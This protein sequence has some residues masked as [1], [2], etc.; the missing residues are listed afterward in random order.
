MMGLWGIYFA[1]K[2]DFLIWKKDGL[3]KEHKSVERELKDQN[4][5]DDRQKLRSFFSGCFMYRLKYEEST[6]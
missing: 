5:A 2:I 6:Q 1:T 3:M 4:F